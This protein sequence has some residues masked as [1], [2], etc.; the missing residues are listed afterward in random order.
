M[1]YWSDF[2][3]DEAR[4]EATPEL[5][6][7]PNDIVGEGVLILE[8]FISESWGG[9]SKEAETVRALSKKK[10]ESF[11]EEKKQ[12][13]KVFLSLENQIQEL[14]GLNQK[15]LLA[16]SLGKSNFS[17]EKQVNCFSVIPFELEGWG[18]VEFNASGESQVNVEDEKEDCTQ[19]FNA[20]L[21]KL[22]YVLNEY[23]DYLRKE[24]GEYELVEQFKGLNLSKI[25]LFS[26]G[27]ARYDGEYDI[28]LYNSTVWAK[29]RQFKELEQ[30]VVMTNG[31]VVFTDKFAFT[32][33]IDKYKGAL[34]V[35]YGSDKFN[36]YAILTKPV[37]N[38]E[39]SLPEVTFDTT[40]SLPENI[41]VDWENR[42]LKILIPRPEPQT[43]VL[44]DTEKNSYYVRI[45]PMFAKT[46]F[47]V[48]G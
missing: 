24:N 17:V 29:T 7:L 1:L 14:V 13:A 21:A 23:V 32:E 35:V 9:I 2:A 22:T 39:I 11:E 47:I 45:I 38:I 34:K 33:K 20:P 25:S 10:W 37:L 31:D 12:V 46:F 6:G 28:K 15:I 40:V 41:Q 48:E 3:P 26:V 44:K 43:I 18:V 27:S 4:F 19:P 42:K 8:S 16:F 5:E 36:I 30:T